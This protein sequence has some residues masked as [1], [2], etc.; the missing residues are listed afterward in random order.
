MKVAHLSAR[1]EG[2]GAANA[3][4]LIHQGLLRLGVQSRLWVTAEERN[5]TEVPRLNARSF[6]RRRVHQVE[7][8]IDSRLMR[9]LQSRTEYVLSSG[10]FGQDPLQVIREDQPDVVQ[11]HWIAGG[12][13][14]LSRL[15]NISVP[16]LWRLPDMWPFCGAE[17]LTTDST[18]Y[19]GGY[20]RK[21]RPAEKHGFDVSRW[22]W[23]NKRRTYQRIKDLTIV[24]PSR[25]L[26]DCARQSALFGDREVVTIKTGCDI[27]TFYPREQEACRKVLGLPADKMIILAGATSL[28]GPWKGADLLVKAVNKIAKSLS[29]ASFE[30]VAFGEGGDELQSLVPC[31]ARSFGPIAS[32]VL[33][34]ILYSAA[35]V[36]VAPSRLENLSNSVLEAMACATPSVTFSVGGMP[37]AIDHCVNGYLAKPYDTDDLAAG[38]MAVGTRPDNEYRLAAR[39]K[40]E[41]EF[42]AEWQAKQ[43]RALYE[44]ILSGQGARVPDYAPLAQVSP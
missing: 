38:I 3:A 37:D 13:I 44:S 2:T 7:R 40:I 26:A 10:F 30:L 8:F 41:Q 6:F 9:G 42:S 5:E 39:K 34:S 29:P 27:E 35:D 23:E 24:T 4:F 14:K 22:A 19:V 32:K 25:W 15:A 21:N 28:R 33:M 18:R 31:N 36:F 43:Y 17:H 12:S 1:S 11:L 16:I 20:S